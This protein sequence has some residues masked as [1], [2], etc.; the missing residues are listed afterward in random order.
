[1]NHVRRTRGP[2]ISITDGGETRPPSG[3]TATATVSVTELSTVMLPKL[4]A[5]HP[6][7][8]YFASKQITALNRAT[9]SMKAAPMRSVTWILGAASG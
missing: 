7:A 8:S 5:D 6:G 2:E 9:P 3:A 1:M 4:P